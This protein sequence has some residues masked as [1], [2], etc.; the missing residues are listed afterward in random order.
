MAL[1]CFL[2]L[3]SRSSNLSLGRLVPVLGDRALKERQLLNH[4]LGINFPFWGCLRLF[5]Y[6][7][8]DLKFRESHRGGLFYAPRFL[9]T[10]SFGI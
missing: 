1:S 2:A 10:F 3:S 4:G 7:G 6:W 5:S 9:P 8:Q